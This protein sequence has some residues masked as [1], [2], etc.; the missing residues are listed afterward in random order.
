ME[1]N[2]V[3]AIIYQKKKDCWCKEK[4]AEWYRNQDLIIGMNYLPRTASNTTEMWQKNSFDGKTIREELSWAHKFGY[5]SI[6]V[7][8]PFVVYQMEREHFLSRIDEFLDIASDFNLK[9]VFVI[10]DDCAF[11]NELPHY[12]KQSEPKPFVHNSC[13]TASPGSNYVSDLFHYPELEEY[14][15]AIISRYKD[16]KRILMWDLYNEPGNN[17]FGSKSLFLLKKAFDWAREINPIQPLTAG[18]WSILSG[19][20]K[21]A[22]FNDAISFELSDVI[23]FHYYTDAEKMEQWLSLVKETGYPVIC[24]EWMARVFFNST[25]ESVLPLFAREGIG[26]YHWGFVNGKTQTHIPWGWDEKKGEPTVWFHDVLK[27][28]GTAYSID[29]MKVVSRIAGDC[30]KQ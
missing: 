10:F 21:D 24:T 28:D 26:S 19:N 6:R 2:L 9:V 20:Q 17:N 1:I 27:A 25:I 18:I 13:W 15:K 23:S 29:E 14:E 16:D 11:S 30:R 3:K 4:A 5:N 8:L 7:F 12:G 22:F